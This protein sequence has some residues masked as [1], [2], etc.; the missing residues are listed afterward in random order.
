MKYA[1]LAGALAFALCAGI[2]EAED[3][4]VKAASTAVAAETAEFEEGTGNGT[5]LKNIDLGDD[6]EDRLEEPAAQ[7]GI[8][9][10]GESYNENTGI[11]DVTES[12]S[13]ME[14]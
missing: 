11:P 14:M 12:D 7:V 6:S 1:V 9:S 3:G 10:P 5:G 13:D 2:C 8:M 4:K